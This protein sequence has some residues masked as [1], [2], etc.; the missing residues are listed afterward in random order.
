MIGGG[1]RLLRENLAVYTNPPANFL[2]IF[3]RSSSAVTLSKKVQLPLIGSSLRV[4]Q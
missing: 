3:A 1:R 4:F 2:F